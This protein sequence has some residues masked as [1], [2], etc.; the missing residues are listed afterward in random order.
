[1][2][3]SYTKI[4]K[5]R[6]ANILLEQRKFLTESVSKYDKAKPNE[7]Q[8][9]VAPSPK[10][11]KTPK[12]YGIFV[13][14]FGKEAMDPN[15]IPEF[16]EFKDYFILYPTEQ[17]AETKFNEFYNSLITKQTTPTSTSDSTTTTTTAKP[18]TTPEG[19]GSTSPS[20]EPTSNQIT[21]DQLIDKMASGFKDTLGL[22]N[23]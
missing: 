22:N 17:A 13:K 16:A 20:S 1:M 10:S 8:W 7:N 6:E 12:E 3:R 9:Y 23:K 11:V 19:E 21:R 5:I 15:S 14:Q 4:R 18:G 2:N